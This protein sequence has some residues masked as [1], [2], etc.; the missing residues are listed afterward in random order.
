MKI[1]VMGDSISIQYGP[2]LKKFLNPKFTYSRKE[3]EEEVSLNFDHPAGAN[4]GDSSMV[5]S[6]FKA[7]LSSH[8]INA[9]LILL[10]CGLHDIKANIITKKN[11][12]PIDLYIQNLEEILQLFKNTKLKIIWLRTTPCNDKIHNTDIST[13]FRFSKDCISYNYAADEL[14]KKNKTPIIDLYS[15]TNQF[16]DDLYY[17]HVHFHPHICEK[18][19]AFIAGWLEGYS[20]I[21]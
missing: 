9:D 18:Q 13:F 5:L 20:Q 12:V 1:Y 2:Y 10:N 16:G 17:D 3:D 7:K 6:F 21:I 15:F 19:G 11:Q 8:K 14:M 4:G